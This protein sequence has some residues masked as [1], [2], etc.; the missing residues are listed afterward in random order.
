MQL[1]GNCS[2]NTDFYQPNKEEK[3]IKVLIVIV[4]CKVVEPLC[5]LVIVR[6]CFQQHLQGLL[7]RALA[8]LLIIRLYNIVRWDFTFY[9]RKGSRLA[10]Q[11]L[12]ENEVSQLIKALMLQ[13][14]ARSYFI[15][16]ICYLTLLHKLYMNFCFLLS[17]IFLS[18]FLSEPP[19]SSSELAVEEQRTMLQINNK[20]D[21]MKSVQSQSK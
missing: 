15:L 10:Q 12:M 5:F 11:H 18:H 7:Q 17:Q 20:I 2:F 21:G 6:S 19:H 1:K 3:D 8:M 14:L 16:S 9:Q 13:T 4:V